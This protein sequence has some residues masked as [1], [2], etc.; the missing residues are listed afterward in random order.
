[1]N[2]DI[3]KVRRDQLVVKH[4]AANMRVNGEPCT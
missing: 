3:D 2:V 4:Q 1:M